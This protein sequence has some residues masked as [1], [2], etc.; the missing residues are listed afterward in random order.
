MTMVVMVMMGRSLTEARVLIVTITII[1]ISQI[2][3][4]NLM[5]PLNLLFLMLFIIELK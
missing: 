3:I 5:T 2:I 1:Q 4:N